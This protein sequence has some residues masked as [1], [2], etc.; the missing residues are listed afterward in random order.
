MFLIYNNK[1]YEINGNENIYMGSFDP[2]VGYE[3]LENV[4]DEREIAMFNDV[5]EK[6]KENLQEVYY[7]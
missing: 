6:I 1:L 2:T 7:E 3:T 4:S 5:L